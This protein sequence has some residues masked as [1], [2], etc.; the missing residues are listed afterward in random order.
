MLVAKCELRVSRKN[1]A[2]D[3]KRMADTVG[4]EPT[5]EL[6]LYTLSRRAPS[7]TRPR[8]RLYCAFDMDDKSG[9]LV[10]GF[11][12]C[13]IRTALLDTI[14]PFRKLRKWLNLCSYEKAY[15]NAYINVYCGTGPCC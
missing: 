15:Q 12:V 3:R 9:Y 4:F 10:F 7:T 2:V 1:K 8:V 6:P 13:Q 14:S 5:K 11:G